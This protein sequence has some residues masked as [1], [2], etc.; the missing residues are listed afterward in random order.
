VKRIGQR[1]AHLAAQVAFLRAVGFIHQ[2]DDV[3]A[4]VQAAGKKGARQFQRFKGLG[5]VQVEDLRQMVFQSPD[6]T[7]VDLQSDEQ[8][9]DL[10]LLASSDAASVEARRQLV[11][12]ILTEGNEL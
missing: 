5:E 6:Y 10:A 12:S 7:I 2:G 3:A 8:L 1:L 9:T 4:V 11:D